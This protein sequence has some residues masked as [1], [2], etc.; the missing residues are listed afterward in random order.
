MTDETVDHVSAL[1]GRAEHAP[2]DP[3]PAARARPRGGAGAAAVLLA[4]AALA[5]AGYAA[6]RGRILESER[7]AGADP[8]KLAAQVEALTHSIEQLRGNA[9]SVRAR[10]D[11]TAKVD[12]SEREELLGLGERA[13]LLE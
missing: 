9:D 8:Q 2:A 3:A 13:R 12:Q 1:T 11:D 10:L 6:W 5:V 7:A 4:V